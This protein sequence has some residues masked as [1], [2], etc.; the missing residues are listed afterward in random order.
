MPVSEPPQQVG[1]IHAIGSREPG[2]VVG[3]DVVG[4]RKQGGVH[5][6]G[7]VGDLAGVGDHL[8]H[9]PHSFGQ[10]SLVDRRGQLDMDPRL[11]DHLRG[12]LAAGPD[13]G[14]RPLCVTANADHRV[15]QSDV[16]DP[17]PVQQHGDRV[18]QRVGLI[19]DDLQSGTETARV[20]RPG[21]LDQGLA[22]ASPLGEPFLCGDQ[23][24]GHRYRPLLGGLGAV[25]QR[26]PMGASV[27][28]GIRLL[29]IRSAPAGHHSRDIS[30]A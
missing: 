14:Q 22:D 13:L 25:Q 10:R 20:I 12:A 2:A 11:L 28:S 24:R 8:R 15:H 29:K 7:I 27:G 4:Q 23:R 30:R 16:A 19:G 5:R 1:H 17:Q 3:G 26:S 18:Q 9:Q 21:D 6:R